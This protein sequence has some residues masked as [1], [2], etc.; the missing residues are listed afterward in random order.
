[1]V[2]KRNKRLATHLLFWA[3]A[4][5]YSVVE[6]Y[7]YYPHWQQN[8]ERN[9]L[10]IGSLSPIIYL[11]LYFFIPKLLF[12]RKYV[13]Y[14]AISIGTLTLSTFLIGRLNYLVLDS[15]FYLGRYGYLILL[16]DNMQLFVFTTA[17]KFIQHWYKNESQ[18][19][20]LKSNNLQS[21]LSL[22][23]SQLNPHFL[24][25]TLNSI[26][27][28]IGKT[29]VQ[30]QEAV[31]KLSELLSHQLYD[32]Q[33]DMIELEKEIENLKNYIALETT[34]YGDSIALEALFPSHVNGELIAPMLLLPLVENAFKHGHTSAANRCYIN[35]RVE[36]ENSKLHFMCRNTTNKTATQATQESIGLRSVKRRLE[37]LYPGKHSFEIDFRE[38]QYCVELTLQLH[39]S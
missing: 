9:L 34:R 30:G 15:D 19:K 26:Y 23:K 35:L 25:N 5:L 36:M 18:I 13:L 7:N 1:M 6:D 8:L 32:N 10:N 4:V 38:N 39:E 2:K 17:V 28:L 21:E 12:P 11:N 3:L 29:P 22:I 37:L 20:E 31:L 14:A 33:K 24:F 16:R 27:Y